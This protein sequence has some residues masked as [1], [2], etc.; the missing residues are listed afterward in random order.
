MMVYIFS[1]YNKYVHRY[2]LVCNEVIDNLMLSKN[3]PC[4]FD[5][6]SVIYGF[7]MFVGFDQPFV[8][9]CVQIP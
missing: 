3:L 8:Q 2:L 9:L 5:S 4:C 1:V 7:D 6:I